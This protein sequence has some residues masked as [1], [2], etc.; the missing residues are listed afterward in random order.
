[1]LMLDCMN[2]YSYRIVKIVE[3]VVENNN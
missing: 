1:M 2:R 3:Y